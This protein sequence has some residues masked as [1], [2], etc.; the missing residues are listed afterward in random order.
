MAVKAQ[1]SHGALSHTLYNFLHGF[2]TL[3]P[4][5]WMPGPDGKGDNLED[6][7]RGTLQC[8]NP[9]C[10]KLL[11]SEWEAAFK[12]SKEWTTAWSAMVAQECNICA[13]LRQERCRVLQANDEA[14]PLESEPFLSALYIHPYNLPKHRVP[15]AITSLPIV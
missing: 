10:L 7:R 4:G 15:C 12:E 13:Q 3:T 2:P 1:R 8:R 9:R 6:V 5:S 11:E 14:A